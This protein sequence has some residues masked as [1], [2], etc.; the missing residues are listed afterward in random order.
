MIDQQKKEYKNHHKIRTILLNDI[1]FTKYEKI[2]NRDSAKSIFDYLRMKHQGNAQVKE[3]KVFA[4]IQKYEAFNM[5]DEEIIENMLSRFQTLVAGLKILDKGYSTGDHVK[6]IIKSLP[7]HWRPMVATLKLSKDLNNNSL[8]ELVSSLRSR[9]I[10][11]EEDEPK[12]K[13]NYVS[14][15]Y[16]GRSKK[17]KA[18]QAET[19]EESE[20]E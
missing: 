9:E 11:P 8:E 20:E 3:T 7:K 4:L 14:L 18:P 17:T 1:S 12:R 2:T 10:E 6:K 19:D 5:K 16:L 15:K 13:S